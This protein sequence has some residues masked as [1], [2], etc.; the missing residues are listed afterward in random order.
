MFGSP[1]LSILVDLV[2]YVWEKE[3]E[4]I[5]SK[6][7]TESFRTSREVWEG[8][9]RKQKKGGGKEAQREYKT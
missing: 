4:K 7:E 6:V 8:I 3:L 9:Y 1:V 2:V 5:S